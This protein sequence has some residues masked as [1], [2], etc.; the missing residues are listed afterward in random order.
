LCK[1]GL[2]AFSEANTITQTESSASVNAMTF[3]PI[4]TL[5][6]SPAKTV[7]Q[8]VATYSISL[9]A[10]TITTCLLLAT[11]GGIRLWREL[12]FKA[13]A[14]E[15]E[16]CPFALE[17][18]PK[19]LGSWQ[20]VEGTHPQLDPEIGRIA[21][22]NAH[23]LREYMDKKSGVVV[24]ALILY[25]RANSVFAHSP[26]VCYPSNGYAL[27][28]PPVED[29]FKDT[30]SPFPVRFRSALFS[31]K[32]GMTN[33]YEEVYYTFH[34]D[35]QWLPEVAN[36]WKLFRYHPGMFKVLLQRVTTNLSREHSPAESL[37][38]EIVQEI[39]IRIAQNKVPT[40][41]A[42]TPGETA[43]R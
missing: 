31:K 9:W 21:G 23:I 12:Q 37:L 32:V 35:Q 41:S 2:V 27:V 5:N 14:H 20:M 28:M 18:F 17:E 1:A 38:R 4:N 42:M 24:L 11:S 13:I 8:S 36:Q 3:A 30:A 39:D 19:T 6:E 40:A 33:R 15:S 26:E 25:G 34:H 7:R 22:S 29:Q 16:R 10:L 43:A